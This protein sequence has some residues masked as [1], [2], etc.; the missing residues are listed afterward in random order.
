MSDLVD[1]HFIDRFWGFI[2][3]SDAKYG[4]SYPEDFGE[5]AGRN[6]FIVVQSFIFPKARIF[7]KQVTFH[8]ISPTNVMKA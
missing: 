6:F 3:T 1:K 2:E 5:D 8:E 4:L 7:E